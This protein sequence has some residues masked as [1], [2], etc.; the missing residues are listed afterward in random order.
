ML[1]QWAHSKRESTSRRTQKMANVTSFTRVAVSSNHARTNA[2]TREGYL[3][4]TSK[5]LM[6]GET[7][8]FVNMHYSITSHSLVFF[9]QDR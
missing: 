7:K 1:K 4:K 3:S 2:N 8:A 5:T 9:S 6:A